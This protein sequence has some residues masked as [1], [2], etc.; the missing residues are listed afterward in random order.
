MAAAPAESPGVVCDRLGGEY[1]S[2]VVAKRLGHS[3]KVAAQH[4]LMSR[5]HHFSEQTR[6]HAGKQMVES[7]CDAQCDACSPDW[8]DVLTLAVILVAGIN[9]AE[10][11]RAAVLARVIAVLTSPTTRIPQ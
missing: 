5:D 9:L 4:Y 7:V 10:P 2:H 6:F 8:I 3:P 11:E 1:P